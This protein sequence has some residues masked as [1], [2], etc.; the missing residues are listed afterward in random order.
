MI[1]RDTGWYFTPTSIKAV[2]VRGGE[3]LLCR[4]PRDE[5]ELPGGW[6]DRQDRSLEDTVRRE[7]FEET[8][9]A[10]TV[11]ELLTAR[12]YQVVEN[13]PVVLV[14]FRATVPAGSRPTGSHEHSA[15][16]FFPGASLPDALP[17]V[18]RTAVKTAL[19][20]P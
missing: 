8:G 19:D 4:N 13:S 12:L 9:L 5:W 16:T 3:I 20:R 1:D 15:V 10:V 18:Y 7:V 11:H 6:P 17:E 2:V 14:V